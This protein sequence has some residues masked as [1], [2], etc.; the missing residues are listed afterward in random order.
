MK[1]RFDCREDTCPALIEYRPI[2]EGCEGLDCPRCAR[3][4]EVHDTD[5]LIRHELPAQCPMCR[6]AEFYK[7]KN[8]PQKTGLII[9]VVAALCSLWWY[10]DNALLAYGI[11]AVAVAVDMA[12]Y[13]MIG[14]VT[15]CYRCSTAYWSVEPP[16]DID[17][18]DLATSEKYL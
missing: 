18:F 12:I 15:V 9:V 6:G 16:P 10:K 14:V 3:H 5:R 13:Y 1:L 8:F 4:Y 11:L 17:W 2:G 7:R